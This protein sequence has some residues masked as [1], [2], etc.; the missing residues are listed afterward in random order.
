MQSK[1]VQDDYSAIVQRLEIHDARL[2]DHDPDNP[3]RNLQTFPEQVSCRRTTILEL[4]AAHNVR[5]APS[6]YILPTVPPR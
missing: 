3:C 5:R 4:P 2:V 6:I 1:A